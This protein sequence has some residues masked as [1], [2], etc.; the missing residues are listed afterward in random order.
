VIEVGAKDYYAVLGVTSRE[1]LHDIKNAYRQL[2]KQCH[3]D[4]AGMEGQEQFQQIQAAYEVLSDPGKRKEYDASLDRR[5]QLSKASGIAPEPLVPRH[6]RSSFNA[7]EPLKPPYE[8]S[9][10]EAPYLVSQGFE[11]VDNDM[12]RLIVNCLRAIRIERF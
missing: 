5:R 2:A 7:P 3:P 10:F 6:D 11:S 4:R 1:S 8:E 9:I 12:T